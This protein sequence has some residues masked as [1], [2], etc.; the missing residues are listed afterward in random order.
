MKPQ[1]LDTSIETEKV[2]VELLRNSSIAKRLALARMLTNSTRKMAK[3][4]IK[5]CNPGKSQRELDLIFVEVVYGKELAEQLREFY[6][7]REK[8]EHQD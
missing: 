8:N 4:A 7:A 3:N 2:Q 6:F 1:S 5:K